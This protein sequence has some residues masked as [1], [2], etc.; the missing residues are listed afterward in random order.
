MNDTRTA[1]TGHNNFATLT[2]LWVVCEAF[3]G[4]IIHGLKLPVSGLLVGSSAVICIG[5]IAWYH[6]TRS[7]VLKATLLVCIF[8]MMLSPQSPPMAYVAVA[9]QGITG[10]LLLPGKN[11]FAV[12][13][14][15]FC[16]LALVESALQRIII[17]SFIYG[18]NLWKVADETVSKLFG[19]KQNAP[20]SLWLALVYLGIHIAAGI[21]AARFTL[22]AI[23]KGNIWKKQYS[24][25]TATNTPMNT[26]GSDRPELSVSRKRKFNRGILLMFLLLGVLYLLSSQTNSR[27][28]GLI[29]GILFR[30][31]ALLALWYFILGPLF[32]KLINRWLSRKSSA[33]AGDIASINRAIPDLTATLRNCWSLSARQKGAGRITLF[34]KLVIIQTLH[35]TDEP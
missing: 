31:T 27:Q 3:L 34:G 8:K 17:L 13:H 28:A 11:H 15:V 21:L 33:Y 14:T 10:A 26:P 6:P 20:V 1:T 22:M 2:A 16:L 32:T 12:R 25:W 30:A 19:L 4:G 24:A 23:R 5:L 7:A 18:K 29:A 35:A 9:F